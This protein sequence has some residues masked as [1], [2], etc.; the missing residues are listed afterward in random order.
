MG[1][2]MYLVMRASVMNR[3]REIGIYRAIGA[4]K[5]NIVFRFAV[6]T[7]V[8]LSLSAFAGYLVI[9]IAVGYFSSRTAF[10]DSSFY[11]P[12]WMAVVLFVFLAVTGIVCGILPVVKL[13]RKTPS[14]ILAKYDI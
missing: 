2:C 4:K 13:L 14:E 3:T 6:E 11:Y 12:L 5:S 1:I 7:A 9:S 10:G 8:V